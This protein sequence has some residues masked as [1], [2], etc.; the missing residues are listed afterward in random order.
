MHNHDALRPSV[1][2]MVHHALNPACRSIPL[3]LHHHLHDLIGH[4]EPHHL[5]GAVARTETLRNNKE[6]R[7]R[8][9]P[10]AQTVA[11]HNN[12]LRPPPAELYTIR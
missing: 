6:T 4:I 8:S 3:T 11:R 5:L 10:T 12:Q 7:C 2:H 9:R 1:Y